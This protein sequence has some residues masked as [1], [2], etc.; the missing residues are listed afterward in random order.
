M[1][2][3]AKSIAGSP[4]LGTGVHTA[5]LARSVYSGTIAANLREAI[6]G[7]ELV[8]ETPLVETRLA[9]D[10]AVSRG[11]VRSALTVLE[12]EGLVRTRP[13]GRL[14]Y[15]G[16]DEDDLT[17]LF[18]V[19]YELE[20]TGIAWGVASGVALDALERAF[21]QIGD[22]GV[23]TEQLVQVDMDFHR[24]LVELSESRFLVQAWLAIAPV[25]QAVI[26][27]GNRR[28]ANQEPASHRERIRGSH[29]LIL[30]ALRDADAERAAELLGEQ[31]AITASMF[32]RIDPAAAARA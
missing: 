6:I 29:R 15:V 5:K 7:G 13:N 19:R 32:R 11:P 14:E 23:A 28:L 10:L 30:A 3:S 2:Q 20:S 4:S 26:A 31:F 12:G 22:P 8:R 24:A 16:F 1:Q 18:R 9:A 25:I 17:D 21:A 27:I